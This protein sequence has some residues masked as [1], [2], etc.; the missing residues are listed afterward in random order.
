MSSPK[1]QSST[2]PGN[3]SSLFLKCQAGDDAAWKELVAR[4]ENLVFSSALQTGLDEDSAADVFQ[5]VW[6]E[7]HRSLL[8]IRDPGAIP[9]WLIVTTRRIAYRHAVLKGKWV[10]DVREDMADPNPRADSAIAAMEQRQE[11]EEAL[12]ALD[13]RC[14]EVLRM[15]FYSD[16]KISYQ[17]VARRTG[18]SE[19]SIGS[20]RSRCLKRLRSILEDR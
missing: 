1:R 18:L 16:R 19:D 15:L 10:R 11:I 9:R 12:G 17:E 14:R 3:D 8:R 5:Q 20:L 2:T 4:Y 6:L 13:D 7:L